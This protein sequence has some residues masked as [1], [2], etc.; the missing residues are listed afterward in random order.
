MLSD[1]NFLSEAKKLNKFFRVIRAFRVKQKKYIKLTS[2]TNHPNE[3]PPKNSLNND[4]AG[5]SWS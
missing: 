3:L 2:I 4:V 1:S 5:I